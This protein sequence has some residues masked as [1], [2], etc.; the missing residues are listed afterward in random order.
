MINAS[1]VLYNPALSE[2]KDLIL[3]L[4]DSKNIHE[5][6]LIDNSPTQSPDFRALPVTYIF[7]GK[8][9]GY[10]AA[11]NIA[12]RKTLAAGI[13]YHLVVNPDIRFDGEIIGEL[14]TYMDANPDIGHL[15][16]KVF[17]PDGKIQYLCKLLTKPSDLIFRRFFP[18][19]WT[20]KSNDKF[21]LRTSGYDKIMEA[22]YLSGCFMLLRTQ[23]LKEIG[24][25]DERFFMYPEDIDLTRR[26]HRKY[27][28]V[29]YPNVSIVHHHEQGSYKSK[30]LLFVH[31][32]NL[33]KYF[34]KYGWFFDPERKKINQETRRKVNLL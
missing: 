7:N 25:F 17:Y 21:E 29:F 13:P 2:I 8:N 1:I 5:V 16:P 6:F 23:A 32:W 15:M 27:R 22:P 31:L 26:M 33:I 3:I 30:K 10:G 34:N 14:M 28:T 24:L 4:R 20:R 18:S 9:L 12:I 11:H 19:S